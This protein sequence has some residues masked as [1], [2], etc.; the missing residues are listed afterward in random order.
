MSGL[1][2]DLIV[3]IRRLRAEPGFLTVAL[4]TL[5][6]G[7][8]ASVAIFTVVN[9]VVLRPLPYPEP[10]RLVLVSPGQNSNIALS[11]AIRDGAPALL[12]TTGIS[13][14][15]LTL[16]G[17]G[18]AA[19]LPAQVIDPGFFAV[20]G[21][22]PALGRPLDA[23][24]RIP[25]RS[26][27]VIISHAVWQR[28]FGGDPAVVGKR[29][30]LDG[31]DAEER[32][33][34]GVMP[35]GFV[36]PFAPPGT[37]TAFWI[38]FHLAPGSTMATDSSWY[39]NRIAGRL[40]AGATVEGAALQVRTTMERVRS[41]FPGL[42]DAEAVRSA[43]AMGLLTSLVGDVQTPLRLLLATVALVLLLACANLANLLM[44]R[45]ERRRQELAVRTAL[46]AQRTRL[47]R[48]QL[49]EGVLLALTG[50]AMGTALAAVILSV[51]RVSERSG[52]PRS[53]NAAMDGRVLAFALAISL[54]SIVGFALIPALRATRGDLRPDLG[55]GRRQ[56]GS[57]RGARR[58]GAVLIAAEVALA[59]VV[60]SGAGLLL[61]SLRAL[62]A[63]DP[64]LDTDRV[65][66][67]ELAPPDTRYR[68]ARSAQYYADVTQRLSALPGVTSIGAIHLLPL[69][70]NNWAFPYLAEG[71]APPSDGPLPSAN[72]RVI[73]P[74]YFRTV[75]IRLLE[76]R[77]VSDA[78]VAT[79]ER[80]GL[81]N[82]TMAAALWP[83]EQAA[84]RTI[85]L[86]G[87]Q[88][89]RVIGVVSDVHQQ[90]L[91]RAPRPEM[92]QPH[93]QFSVAS[94]VVMVRSAL[95]PSQL[96]VSVRRAI[97]GLNAEV[98][99]A[100]IQPLSD[101]LDASMTQRTFFAG[102]LTFFG[103]LALLLGA[104]GV[105]GVMA[106]AVGGRR[107]EFGI[108]MALGATGAS[109]VRVAMSTGARPLAIGILL[110]VVG[111][112]TTLRLLASML[113]QVSATDPGTLVAATS[114]LALVGV[115]AIWIP[116]RR[117]SRVAPSQALRAD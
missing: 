62:R 71:H 45:G 21:V 47:I 49:A 33:V 43:G 110:G 112:L 57:T 74:G 97:E 107:H 23:E 13:F 22:T 86:F 93:T 99:I 87:N 81:I 88:P 101:V 2:R 92:Y 27:V 82:A 85:Q 16:S 20:F 96:V 4:S 64:G 54:L 42:I 17:E 115:L 6:L 69:T 10:D 63:V 95:P 90:A 58:V 3:G 50:G 52:L 8:G 32:T 11:D 60:V 89:F 78:D 108:R 24:T 5:A 72:F 102:V 56:V 36:A 100:S 37:E 106:Y 1:W 15:G 103:A 44:A 66:A 39:V 67:V 104:V 68:D 7:I 38:P 111:V 30:R 109:V 18:A 25:Q 41:H 105:Y 73:T 70:S 98:P 28:T 79:S 40:R 29:I 31:Y 77:D 83:G 117:A 34:V 61:T 116:S 59:L 80:V 12:A 65:L 91:D 113:Y 53:G 35:R 55:S 48:E 76:G 51:L 114:G 84:G 26:D 46:G 19:Q 9:A 14:W 75:G 94:M